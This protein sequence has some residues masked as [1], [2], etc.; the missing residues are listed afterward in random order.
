MEN[1]TE[2]N[3]D[4]PTSPPSFQVADVRQVLGEENIQLQHFP[5]SAQKN[6]ECLSDSTIFSLLMIPNPGYLTQ[7]ISC[8]LPVPFTVI[9]LAR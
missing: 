9:S 6:D 7:S 5:K 2:E 4:V 1:W 3:W 8:L